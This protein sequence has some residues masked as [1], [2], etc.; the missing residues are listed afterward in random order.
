MFIF[1]LILI[2]NAVIMISLTLLTLLAFI[3]I[4]L[5]KICDI[6]LNV[7]NKVIHIH[8]KIVLAKLLQKQYKKKKLIKDIESIIPIIEEIYYSPGMK[9]YYLCLQRFEEKSK[10]IK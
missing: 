8:N 3:H 9:G 5:L 2:F 4:I 6:I 1:E 10:Q 7:T